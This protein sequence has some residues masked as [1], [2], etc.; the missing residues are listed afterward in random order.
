MP[1]ANI[2]KLRNL[3]PA[4]QFFVM[5]GQTEATARLTYLP[6][7]RLDE[8]QGSVG[9]PVRGVEIRVFRADQT[10]A[11]NNETGDVVARGPNVMLGYL[12]DVALSNATLQDGWL[13][14]G[15]IGHLDDEGFLYLTGRSVEMIKS[16]A[17]RISPGEIEAEIASM[18]GVAE[19]GV[20]SVSD[21]L[22]GEAIKAVVVLAP[23]VS[24]NERTV[25]AHCR[26]K[27]GPHKV[28]KLVEFAHSLPYTASGKLRRSQ[29]A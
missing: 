25:K 27:L 12:G 16:G 26:E 28:P 20:T 4:A 1:W 8:K 10:R 17:F 14:T 18:P 15:D 22:L 13:R 3:L 11:S 21:D 7:E 23:G 9:V 24:I 5:Y 6:P 29:L 19:V 2:G